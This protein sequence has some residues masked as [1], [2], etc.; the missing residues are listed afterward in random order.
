MK[1][2]YNIDKLNYK[3]T[4]CNNKESPDIYK[5]LSKLYCDKKMLLIIDTRTIIILLLLVTLH[6]PIEL[7]QVLYIA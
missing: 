7:N 2:N 1:L 5:A 4:F 3:A 6:Q